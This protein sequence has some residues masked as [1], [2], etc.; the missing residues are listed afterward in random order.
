MALQ[1]PPPAERR[2]NDLGRNRKEL[3]GEL[4]MEKIIFES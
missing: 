2:M 1:A 4:E 3:G